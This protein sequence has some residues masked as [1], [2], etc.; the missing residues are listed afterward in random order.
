MTIISYR[1][2]FLFVHIMKCGGTSVHEIW[3]RNAAFGDLV[4]GGTPEAEILQDIL[5]PMCGVTKHLEAIKMREGLGIDYELFDSY[6]MIREPIKILESWFKFGRTRFSEFVADSMNS[7]MSDPRSVE[8]ATEFFL[9]C[10]GKSSEAHRFPSWWFDAHGDT[11]IRAIKSRSF[12]E[13]AESVFDERWSRY[14]RD[15]VCDKE[16]VV[17]VKNVIRLE[18][19]ASTTSMLRKYGMELDEL[20]K[21]N[22]SRKFETVW[23]E[24]LQKGYMNLLADEYEFWRSF[25]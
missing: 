2:R 3:Q 9:D 25:G 15:F 17:I 18:D 10:L 22:A 4:V 19:K 1:R 12:N 23:D 7:N 5:G 16:G 6:A 11:L 8:N 21:R 20:P 24:D 14:L 13:F